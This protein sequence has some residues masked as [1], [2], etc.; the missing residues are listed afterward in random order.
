MAVSRSTN[1][2]GRTYSLLVLTPIRPG[3]EDA[4]RAYLAALPRDDS[5]LARVP[6][7]HM[8]RLLI[9]D[10]MPAPPSRSDL[11]DP[12]DGPYLLFTC[13]FDGDLDSYLAGLCDLL[14]PEAAEIWGRCIGC[15]DP[16]EGAALRAYLGRNQIQSGFAF[17]AYGNASVAQVRSALDKRERLADFVVRAQDMTPAARRKAFLEEFG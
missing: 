13:N 17:A 11:A 3:E 14:A 2:A 1:I 15:P 16:P 8:A 7:T 10:E 12:L 6:R 5:P 4:L 9:I